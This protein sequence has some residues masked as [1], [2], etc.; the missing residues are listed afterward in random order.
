MPDRDRV[1]DVLSTALA[2]MAPA[3]AERAPSADLLRALDAM[4]GDPRIVSTGDLGRA[5]D[6]SLSTE[7]A[8]ALGGNRM[9]QMLA[10]EWVVRERFA[11]WMITDEG[12]AEHGRLC[13]QNTVMH[14]EIT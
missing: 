1:R 6:P 7:R 14:F 12:R 10:R 2:A 11:R 13:L 4:A 8:C 5:L 3:P 9:R